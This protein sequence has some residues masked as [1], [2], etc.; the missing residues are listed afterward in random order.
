MSDQRGMFIAFEGGEGT[1]KT[2]QV[3]AL[4]RHLMEVGLPVVDTREP[5]GTPVAESIRELLLSDELHGCDP[6]C[7]ALLFAAA[8]ADHTARLIDPALR[9][10]NWVLCDR[11][12]DSSVAYQGVARGLGAQQ[13]REVSLTATRGRVPDL[14]VVLDVDPRVGLA[15]ANDGNRLEAEE[16]TFHETVRQALLDMAAA[17]PSKYRVVSAAMPARQVAVEVWAGLRDAFPRMLGGGRP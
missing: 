15:R 10:G 4:K 8:R 7:E 6:W 13:V 11:F 14:T 1:G 9:A 3:A 5:G 2:T 17:S 16:I 12:L